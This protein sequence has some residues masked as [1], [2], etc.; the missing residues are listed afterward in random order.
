M[1]RLEFS[2]TMYLISLHS[3]IQIFCADKSKGNK[4]KL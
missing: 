3:C 4:L 2:F 1:K